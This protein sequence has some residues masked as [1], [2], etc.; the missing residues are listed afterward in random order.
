MTFAKASQYPLVF[1]HFGVEDAD[2][3]DT[4]C[5]PDA[6]V[7]PAVVG[8]ERAAVKRR[9]NVNLGSTIVEEKSYASYKA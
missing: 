1:D 8:G 4:S 5:Y 2:R 6:P 9:I 3:D 7:F